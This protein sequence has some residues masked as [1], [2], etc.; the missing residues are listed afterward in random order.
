[1]ERV[2]KGL[3]PERVFTFFE[4]ISRIPRGSG[5]E[6][7]VSDYL[8]EFAKK[9]G[10]KVQRDDALNVVIDKPA[11]PGYEDRPKV[12]L[13]GHMD[14]VCVKE[15]GIDHDFMKDP[16][17]LVV[18]GGY[19]RADG[20]SLG[21]D[22]GNAVSICLAILDDESAV[23]P[24]LQAVFTTE[25]E[26]G[27]KGAKALDSSMLDGT[28]LIGLDYSQDNNVLVS[29][30][31][32]TTNVFRVN[33]RKQRTEESGEKVAFRI[34]LK[35]LTGGHSGIE[36]IKGRANANR[37]MGEILSALNETGNLELGKISGGVKKNVIP[38]WAEAVVI[39]PKVE[40]ARAEDV[41]ERTAGA[42]RKEYRNTDPELMVSSFREKVPD[43]CYPR[44]VTERVLTLLDL[45]PDGLQ[46]YL[47]GER[48]MTKSSGNLGMVYETED[49]I[50]MVS[51][52]RSNSE[53]EH[54]QILRRMKRAA[55]AADAE[56]E[57]EGRT[58][59]WEYDPDAG[60]T[61]KV[62]DIW[63]QVRGERPPV[64][65]IHA[66]V[67]T[68][69]ILEKLAAQGKRLEAVNLGVKNYEVHTPRERM[70]IASIGR[71]YEFLRALL[72]RIE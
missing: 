56:F 27:L 64:N 18:D 16:I 53:Y 24:P 11:S 35:G 33:G 51:M 21:A 32:S 6:R 67:E 3:E 28:Y 8:V 34:E 2:L 14:M 66:E 44:D 42:I 72:E 62:R 63:Q 45:I 4:E 70:E 36:I 65:I 10:L 54:D 39:L 46:N 22:D 71:T 68:G 19:L 52:V 49:G 30:A 20:T 26:V 47:D 17:R 55:R 57:S 9:R 1:M 50:E 69:L 29:C 58:P 7:A 12:I 5:N 60:F 41:L 31:G 59:V 48:T 37:L 61:E 23:H 43:S 15:P 40:A 13:Q 25:E 38:Y